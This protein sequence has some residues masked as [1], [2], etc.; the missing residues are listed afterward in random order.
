MNQPDK[1]CYTFGDFRLDEAERRLL[2]NGRAISLAP[3]V[4]DTL[5]LLV[6][7]SGHL[8]EK[9]EFMRQIWADTFVG[10]D[11][12][13]RN[14]SIL[15]KALG[16]SSDSQSCIATVPTRGYRFVA[17]VQKG[18]G[19][20]RS[21]AAKANSVPRESARQPETSPSPLPIVEQNSAHA[22]LPGLPVGRAPSLPG[23][24]NHRG[25]WRRRIVFGAL[26]L[27]AGSFAGL[28]TFF[29][30]APPPT[31]RVTSIAQLSHSA[32]FD[33]WGKII[34]DGTRLFYLQR[35]GDHWN[36]MQIPVSG[37]ESQPFPVPFRNTR[38]LDISPD[39][40]EF[41]IAPFVRRSRSLSLWTMPLVGGTPHRLGN[42][43]ADDAVFSP[44]STRIAYF[45]QD[46]VYVC[47][48]S[49]SAVRKL[50]EMPGD[51][52]D[53][54]WS[55]D[56][57]VL[58]FRAQ[59]P[60]TLSSTFWEVSSDGLNLHPL[61]PSWSAW[62]GTWS[63]DGRYYFFLSCTEEVCGIWALREKRRF[64]YL[65][66][67]V[68][69]V[70]LTQDT[71]G[72]SFIAPSIDGH[73]LFAADRRTPHYELLQ[74]DQGSKQF[75]TRLNGAIVGAVD[76]SR[77][78]D[79]IAWTGSNGILWQS[80]PDGSRRVQLTAEFS[81]VLGP[82]WSPDGTRI[83]F[84]AKKKERPHNIYAV[85]AE[86]GAVEE[87]L[88]EDVIHVYPDWAPDGR[89]IAYSTGLDK[90]VAPPADGAVYVLDL[91]TR[92]TRKVPG[93]DGLEY[94]RWSPDG[95]YLAALSENSENAML[96]NFQTRRWKQIAHGHLLSGLSWSK[97]GKYLYFED[98]LEPKEPV[99]RMRTGDA[100][101]ERWTDFDSVLQSGVA[102]CQFSGLAP[103]G[104]VLVIAWRGSPEIYSLDLDLP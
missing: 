74:Q 64:P 37:G 83:V 78:G 18:D 61:L 75:V 50:A 54:A 81:E 9:D 12:L 33:P 45:T 94:P 97:D 63:P 35:E 6:K 4:F 24:A 62:G 87:L 92:E 47:S 39:R 98:I 32:R 14:I 30:L 88:P 31:P 11:A 70:R 26:V 59:D 13:A 41:L 65:S 93:S 22:P 55:P 79:R 77:N 38:I 44:D 90:N 82:R 49:G 84:N 56:G 27:S 28:V 72:F 101:P 80:R 86:G 15:R 53:L 91:Q 17:E 52:A 71:A 76:Y 19:R 34:T 58:R 23:E 100:H 99:Y 10:E 43:I 66:R 102:R 42:I 8:V 85:R 67:A 95:R 46:G 73:R 5:L 48:R 40:T 29:L 96:F 21:E 103:D 69:P 68:Q 20:N 2:R 7:N 1:S 3:K 60:K 104:S 25:P 36:S 89:S 51:H 16:G 57:K